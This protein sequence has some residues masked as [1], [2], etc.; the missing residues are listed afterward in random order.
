MVHKIVA[1]KNRCSE[2][3]NSNVP[4]SVNGLRGASIFYPPDSL[5]FDVN[6]SFMCHHLY[7]LASC[8]GVKNGE[9]RRW[10]QERY[11]VPSMKCLTLAQY[12]ELK[13]IVMAL[14][15]SDANKS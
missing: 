4:K 1:S 9:L 8:V 5:A 14:R 15:K 6:G 11:S 2:K 12:K 10:I 3:N 7:D 13:K